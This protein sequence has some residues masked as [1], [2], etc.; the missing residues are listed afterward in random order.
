[1]N[2]AR[3]NGILWALLLLLATTTLAQSEAPHAEI[4][5]WDEMGRTTSTEVGPDGVSRENS[6]KVCLDPKWMPEAIYDDRWT[7]NSVTKYPSGYDPKRGPLFQHDVWEAEAKKLVSSAEVQGWAGGFQKALM[8]VEKLYQEDN[9]DEAL[10][11]IVEAMAR[12]G[13][14]QEALAIASCHIHSAYDRAKALIGIA[15]AQALVGE[16]REAQ[17]TIQSIDNDQDQAKARVII[18]K[19]KKA[20][21]FDFNKV[22]SRARAR[23]LLYNIINPK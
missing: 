23:T 6:T 19:L 13:K 17:T 18:D 5:R 14:F 16:F 15:E 22:A 12:A 8:T 4:G 9:Q 11:S 3:N 10:I 7:G 1:M 2:P 21:T 20:Q